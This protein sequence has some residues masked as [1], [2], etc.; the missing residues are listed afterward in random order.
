MLTVFACAVF[1]GL[2]GM[3]VFGQAKK[4]AD[5]KE[6][7]GLLLW[8]DAADANS[9]I[10]DASNKVSK[11]NDKSG[12]GLNVEQSDAA[13]QPQLVP[14]PSIG[15]GPALAFEGAE[16]ETTD[17][18]DAGKAFDGKIFSIFALLRMPN[19]QE[20]INEC[21]NIIST[22]SDS[23]AGW[24][25]DTQGAVMR[26]RGF[27]ATGQ[28]CVNDSTPLKAGM[29]YIVEGIFDGKNATIFVRNSDEP[30]TSNTAVFTMDPSSQVLRIGGK[31]GG[32]GGRYFGGSIAEVIIY[33]QALDSMQRL[34]VEQYLID[35][36]KIK[37]SGK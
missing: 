20:Q 27:N 19:D 6:V 36:W 12:K 9:I 18:L 28:T 7:P 3:S 5:P 24:S 26:M 30:A 34:S 10:K 23:A 4:M 25:F 16:T 35:K 2:C 8:L 15:T 21:V 31:T 1:V 17:N 29:T 32:S 11:W 13:R 22:R 33:D 14:A 37:F